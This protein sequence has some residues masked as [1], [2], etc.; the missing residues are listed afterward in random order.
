MLQSYT[1]EWIL[2][3]GWLVYFIMRLVHNWLSQTHIRFEIFFW[4]KIFAHPFLLLAVLQLLTGF[5]IPPAMPAW[6]VLCGFAVF[7]SGLYLTYNAH[8]TLGMNY[9]AAIADKKPRNLVTR[10]PYGIIRHPIYLGACI[11]WL[12]FEIAL[13][14]PLIFSIPVFIPLIIWQI[15]REE[16]TLSSIFEDAWSKY[17]QS[18]P[19]KLLPFIF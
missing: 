3:G 15:N 7:G 10:G 5:G 2:A 19:Y 1:V 17:K 13:Y 16:K 18:T 6:S 11:M 4:I 12:G 14:S 9:S 8:V